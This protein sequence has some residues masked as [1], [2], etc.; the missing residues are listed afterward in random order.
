MIIDAFKQYL[1][2]RESGA[3]SMKLVP[4]LL[5]TMLGLFSRRSSNQGNATT[6]MLV[7]LLNRE[8]TFPLRPNYRNFVGQTPEHS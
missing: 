2:R 5:S 6:L 4:L 7:V 1:S 8:D 3:E